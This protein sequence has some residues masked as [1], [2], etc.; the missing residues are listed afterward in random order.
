VGG[1][2]GAGL[3]YKFKGGWIGGLEYRWTEFS[4]IIDPVTTAGNFWN[5][6]TERH[7]VQQNTVRVGL[8]YL[9]NGPTFASILAK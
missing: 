6:Y 7:T 4:G 1:T 2:V 5:G 9:L 8:S 3:E